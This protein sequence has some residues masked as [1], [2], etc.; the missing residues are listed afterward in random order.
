MLTSSAIAWAGRP[1]TRQGKPVIIE[2]PAEVSQNPIALVLRRRLL[3]LHYNQHSPQRILSP[4][5]P[6]LVL[7]LVLLMAELP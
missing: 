3:L 5:F 6:Y 7:G 2:E 4:D 1:P